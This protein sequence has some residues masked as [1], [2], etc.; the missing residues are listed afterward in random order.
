MRREPIVEPHLVRAGREGAGKG[1][2]AVLLG[3]R[4][5]ERCTIFDARLQQLAAER[6]ALTVLVERHQDRHVLLLA[7]D[8]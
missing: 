5:L 3:N 2:F 4:R 7:A 1:V 8:A 6:D